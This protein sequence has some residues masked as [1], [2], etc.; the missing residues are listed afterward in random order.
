MM[1]KQSLLIGKI[2]DKA[3]QGKAALLSKPWTLSLHL[4]LLRVTDHD[5][6]TA[7]NAKH[8]SSLLSYGNGS[9]ATTSS[10]VEALMDRLQTTRNSAVALK[11]LLTVHHIIKHGSFI[12]QDQLSVCPSHGGRNYLNLSNFRDDSDPLFWELSSWVRWYA[13][14]VEQLLCTSRMLGFFLGSSSSGVLKYQDQGDNVSCLANSDLVRELDSLVDLVAEICKRPDSVYKTGNKL[15]DWIV[16]LLD[17]DRLSTTSEISIRVDEFNKRQ[18][19]LSFGEAVQVVCALKR[20]EESKEK[21]Q[22]TKTAFMESFWGLIREVKAKVGTE[23]MYRE[24]G[25]LSRT[26]ARRERLS[27]SARFAESALKSTQLVK[28]P[29]GRIITERV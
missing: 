23:R 17:E 13:Q 19:C 18:S 26:V 6:F 10:V 14:Y 27:E 3:S 29:S 9:R 21:V 4:A 5:P 25:N 28:F 11:C 8:L 12:I 20:L 1:K 16:K 22:S 15:L 2:K 24:E 7:P